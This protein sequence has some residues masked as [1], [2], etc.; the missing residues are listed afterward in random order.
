MYSLVWSDMIQLLFLGEKHDSRCIQK[1]SFHMLWDENENYPHAAAFLLLPAS[2]FK[3][4]SVTL[5]VHKYSQL[6]SDPKIPKDKSPKCD[7]MMK[8]FRTNEESIKSLT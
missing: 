5:T 1:Q 4:F 7:Y 6:I 2:T 3:F 8:I